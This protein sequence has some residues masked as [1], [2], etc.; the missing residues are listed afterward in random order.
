MS[1][2]GWIILLVILIILVALLLNI[3][4][5]KAV[6][7]TG[8]ALLATKLLTRPRVHG[9]GFSESL[10]KLFGLAGGRNDIVT[11]AKELEEEHNRTL[12]LLQRATRQGTRVTIEYAQTM[13][14]LGECRE[15][16]QN[17]RRALEE[18]HSVLR[19]AKILSAE[20]DRNIAALQVEA[21]QDL[22]DLQEL[23]RLAKE[24]IAITEKLRDPVIDALKKSAQY[25]DLLGKFQQL[26]NELVEAKKY[27]QQIEEQL[28]QARRENYN[29]E[30]A[31]HKALE[32]IEKLQKNIAEF[33]RLLQ[34]CERRKVE[35]SNEL[36][37]TKA[38]HL[39]Q[40]EVHQQKTDSLAKRLR[41]SEKEINQLHEELNEAY[42]QRDAALAQNAKDEE[43]KRNL[44][45]LIDKVRADAARLRET[46]EKQC[47]E[48]IQKA[49][50]ENNQKHLQNISDLQRQIKD[51][52]ELEE[53]SRLQKVETEAANRRLRDLVEKLRQDSS[54][55]VVIERLKEELQRSGLANADLTK[56]LEAAK[57]ENRQQNELAAKLQSELDSIRIRSEE[58][59]KRYAQEV[60][61]ERNRN[62]AKY[63]EMEKAIKEAANTNE[64]LV[65][66]RDLLRVQIDNLRRGLEEARI[67]GEQNNKRAE[68]LAQQLQ[69]RLRELNTSEADKRSLEE[70]LHRCNE[71]LNRLREECD[72]KIRRIEESIIKAKLEKEQLDRLYSDIQ[73][74]NNSNVAVIADL[75]KT[76]VA[77]Q[78]TI[79]DLEKRL[80]A[81]MDNLTMSRRRMVELETR[82]N[83]SEQTIRDLQQ[84]GSD[85]EKSISEQRNLLTRLGAE[86][87]NRKIEIARLANEN[88]EI[89]PLRMR[90]ENCQKEVVLLQQN[91]KT[92]QEQSARYESRIKTLQDEAQ[93]HYRAYNELNKVLTDL[94]TINAQDFRNLQEQLRKLN[95]QKEQLDKRI[96]ELQV[97][98][99]GSKDNNGRLLRQMQ[100]MRSELSRNQ[101]QLTDMENRLKAAQDR[102]A[103]DMAAKDST[104]QKQKDDHAGQL[105]QLAEAER[106][107]REEIDALRGQ[108]ARL[109]GENADKENTIND[110][111]TRLGRADADIRRLN[112]DLAEMRRRLG[113]A[114]TEITRLQAQFDDAKRSIDELRRLLGEC[115]ERN[116]K[117]QADLAAERVAHTRDVADREAQIKTAEDAR[118]R[119]I[120]DL[121]T[122]RNDTNRAIADREARIKAAED[123]RANAEREVARLRALPPPPPIVVPGPP[124]PP[125]V[126]PGPGV[127]ADTS[128]DGMTDFEKRLITVTKKHPEKVV[129]IMAKKLQRMRPNT[130]DMKNTKLKFESI[131]RFLHKEMNT[132][133]EKDV[134]MRMVM[135]Y[136]EYKKKHKGYTPLIQP[137]DL[138]GLS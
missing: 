56:A 41:D 47:Q 2:A 79:A 111:R 104:I 133:E 64:R 67:L 117:C 20:Q 22:E 129:D 50:A 39:A 82:I 52:T 78:Q 25:D 99:D 91:L 127:Y 62:N 21:K 53:E 28:R 72:Q 16:L 106:K 9:G 63:A 112:D 60:E 7:V 92:C 93:E 89:Q 87:E 102:Y 40:L 49:I 44:H 24:Q 125:I 126:V 113:D 134:Y 59:S 109:S 15:Q 84:Q 137:E 115:E 46:L 119:A 76:R 130:V 8:G 136:L 27:V 33:R 29:I 118:A 13:R 65:A 19:R 66:E 34:E 123:A 77:N 3:G 107:L 132:T 42:K 120:A 121:V 4:T 51:L 96:Q 69:G 58:A 105:R 88:A 98:L 17:L 101:L 26:Q 100:D 83:Q 5:V 138:T 57:A 71:S 94:R 14:E 43:A 85:K 37:K 35:L 45:A 32:E 68:E 48:L 73:G 124:P 74:K 10:A 61:A 116:R 75:E 18:C 81:C 12:E 108:A 80:E 30:D 114:N 38:D 31:R 1:S 103:R 86:L 70:R 128:D 36:E 97:E 135:K 95:E 55:V 23:Y 131:N 11:V 122:L 90:L 54:N 110:F 6:G